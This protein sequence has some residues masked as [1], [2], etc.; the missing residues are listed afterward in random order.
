MSRQP[1]RK[2][3]SEV[4]T[5]LLKQPIYT[6]IVDG[7]NL[8][9]IS[10]VDTTVNSKGEKIGGIVQFFIKL[11]M[12]LMK[13]DFD[14]VYV[15]WDGDNSGQL[16]YNIY[17]EYKANRDKHYA[18]SDY[19]KY[20]EDYARKIIQHSKSKQ[21]DIEK[22]EK[23]RE[24]F[25][26]EKLQVQLMLEELFV[27]QLNIAEIE[28]DDLIAYY[29]NHKKEDENV[30]IVSGDRDLS[31][32]L[33]PSVCIFLPIEQKFLTYDNHISM[34]GYHPSNVLVKKIIC[35]DS[36]D[37]IKGI[38]GVGEKT[39]FKLFPEME[40]KLV[41][42]NEVIQ[43]AERISEDRKKEKKKPLQS[44]ENIINK[45]TDGIQGE[46]IYEINE[47][48]INLKKPLLTKDAIELLESLTYAPIDP[49]GRSY[50]NLYN[51]ILKYDIQSLTDTGK[52]SNFFSPFER[53]ISKE[54]KRFLQNN[55][56][57]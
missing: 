49:E 48:I 4:H 50:E 17:P 32:L 16:R 10:M 45:V 7:H 30:V 20:I 33:S 56:E 55:L 24:E 11:R 41:T 36:S 44:V 18:K 40:Q 42:L 54:K 23:E 22:K 53:I 15:F 6:L 8:M 52:F 25:E 1:V 43:H 29:V 3:I 57:V 14:Y 21:E 51:L 46:E 35:G 12:M 19:D 38:K 26:R 39:L 2:I 5:D 28:G 9:R 34:M 47:K 37:N 27:R 13:K 31:Q